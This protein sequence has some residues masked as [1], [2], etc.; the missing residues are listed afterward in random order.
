VIIEEAIKQRASDIHIEPYEQ[1][2]RVRL[3]I[4]GT[5]MT[6]LDPA[7]SYANGLA[8][9]IKIMSGLD[10]SERR[11]PQDGR[12]KVRKDGKVVD[13]RVVHLP[14]I[15]G[16]KIVLRLLD[17]TDLVLDINRLGLS[18]NDLTIL[19]SSMYK[20]KGMI[21]VTGPTGSGKTT[22]IYSMLAGLNRRDA[23]YFDRRR[24]HRV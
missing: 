8:S 3:R 5:L 24:S 19:L 16:E 17:N 9:R 7:K 21:L 12:F 6:V 18:E 11:L 14:G 4:D 1:Q 13:F 22:T 20:S 23:Q 2:A 15:Y 10:I